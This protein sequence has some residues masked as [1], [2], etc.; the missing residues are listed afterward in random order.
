MVLYNLCCLFALRI[1]HEGKTSME[2]NQ[3]WELTC[4]MKNAVAEIAGACGPAC[5]L[6]KVVSVLS[7]SFYPVRGDCTVL[8]AYVRNWAGPVVQGVWGR[9]KSM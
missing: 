3:S 5:V 2:K 6:I 9:W 4:S 1:C 7:S 8:R